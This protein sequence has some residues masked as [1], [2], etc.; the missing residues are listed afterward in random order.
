MPPN[1]DP[2]MP[3]DHHDCFTNANKFCHDALREYG[4]IVDNHCAARVAYA[5]HR[6]C[7]GW[8]MSYSAA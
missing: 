1:N 4:F 7:A 2:V 8:R 6:T 5:D 3:I